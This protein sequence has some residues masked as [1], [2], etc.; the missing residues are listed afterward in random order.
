M[1]ILQTLADISIRRA[2]GFAALGIGT[3]MLSLSFDLELALRS[4][5]TLTTI[6]GAVAWLL[7]VI[8]PQRDI[9]RTELWSML[10][11]ERAHLARGPDEARL[12][13]LAGK[14][15]RERLV[16]HAGRIA[17]AALGMWGLVALLLLVRSVAGT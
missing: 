3:V 5:A 14:V 17:V 6:A 12:R 7:A 15:L 16:W 13:V 1:D 2:C 10:L 9:R 11:T 8:A 4:G